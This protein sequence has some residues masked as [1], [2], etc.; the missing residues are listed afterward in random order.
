MKDY[1]LYKRNRI[2]AK[3]NILKQNYI[4]KNKLIKPA[5]ER[6]I[7][8]DEMIKI[9]AKYI[10]RNSI[11]FIIN[12]EK[13]LNNELKKNNDTLLAYKSYIQ[14]KYLDSLDYDV[15]DIINRIKA[16]K[17]WFNKVK[18]Q[19]KKEHVSLD[20][21]LIRNAKYFIKNKKQ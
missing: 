5:Q 20:K 3:I 13:I 9:Q 11:D 12:K 2:N 18:E 10:F 21:M 1:Y 15:Y 8:M 4:I 7:S 17:N 19:A 6:N 14:I 16:N